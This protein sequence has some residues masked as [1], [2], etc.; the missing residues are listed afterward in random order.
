MFS[1]GLF[2]ALTT[3]LMASLS[4]QVMRRTSGD[5]AKSR[6]A[7]WSLHDGDKARHEEK[8]RLRGA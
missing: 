2:W 6:V 1:L 4:N 5:L 3:I 8:Y 7:R